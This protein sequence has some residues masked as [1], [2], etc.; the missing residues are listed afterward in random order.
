MLEWVCMILVPYIAVAPHH[1]IPLLL[2]DSFTVHMKSSI[3]TAIQALGVQVEFIPPGCT[4]L[5]Q[6]VDVGYN[7]AFKAK[8]WKEY[9]EWLMHQDPD[10]PIP[11][12]SHADISARIIAAEENI[13]K[14][15]ITNAWRK[16][17]YSYF[18]ILNNDGVFTG[19]DAIIGDNPNN[20]NDVEDGEEGDV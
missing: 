11:A 17:G 1:I 18:G 15:T 3:V 7:K 20:V 14:E 10:Q 8:I 4:G 19:D 5:L 13:T 12:T 16:T 2:L 9:N 6:P